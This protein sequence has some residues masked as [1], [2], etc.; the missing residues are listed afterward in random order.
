[1]ADRERALT[2]TSFAELLLDESPDALIALTPEGRIRSWNRGARD[3]FG[4]A[5]EE[6]VGRAIDE[7]TVPEEGRTEARSALAD[8]VTKRSIQFETVRRHKNGSLIHLTVSMR[9]I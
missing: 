3:I 7:L 6:A 5:A 4:Y 2:G 1:M 8:A 9:H